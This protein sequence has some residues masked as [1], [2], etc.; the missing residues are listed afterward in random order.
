MKLLRIV[1]FVLGLPFSL[2]AHAGEGEAAVRVVSVAVGEDVAASDARVTQAR[3][4]IAQA[5]HATGEADEQAIAAASVRLARHLFDVTKQKVS[6]LDV[7]E[8]IATRARP[9]RPLQ[10]TTQR[11]FDLRAKQKLDHA[12]ALAAMK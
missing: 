12:G 2:A 9:G 5:M 7:L 10:E 11:Y 4:W 1:V 3:Q 6:P 8:A